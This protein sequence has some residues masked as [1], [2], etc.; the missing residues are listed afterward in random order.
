MR[1]SGRRQV[2]S[3]CGRV[4]AYTFDATRGVRRV[5]QTV[6]DSHTLDLATAAALFSS[7]GLAAIVTP[8]EKLIHSAPLLHDAVFGVLASVLLFWVLGPLWWLARCD[9][10]P[11]RLIAFSIAATVV[12]SV[13]GELWN[14]L[15][16]EGPFQAP[17]DTAIVVLNVAGSALLA[18]A[19]LNWKR[20]PAWLGWSLVS[21][22]FIEAIEGLTGITVLGNL[23]VTLTGV[24][25]SVILACLAIVLLSDRA[26]RSNPVCR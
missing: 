12:V 6:R 15:V 5:G 21:Y 2:E 7:I 11:S 14:L 16:F 26:V 20:M 1:S 9:G 22:C 3:T 23:P 25:W 4:T 19:F 24:L 8:H 13:Y 18:I 17:L 10:G